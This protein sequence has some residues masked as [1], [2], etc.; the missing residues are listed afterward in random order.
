MT[1]ATPSLVKTMASC[2]VSCDTENMDACVDRC[3]EVY[4]PI[5]KDK[6]KSNGREAVAER[7]STIP[8]AGISR[9]S[10]H[11][12]DQVDEEAHDGSISRRDKLSNE[13]EHTNEG[14]NAQ[15]ESPVKGK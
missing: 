8:V 3:F 12:A 13:K 7:R 6:E 2:V 1:H 5:V 11:E 10:H 14:S 15:N 4:W 9:R